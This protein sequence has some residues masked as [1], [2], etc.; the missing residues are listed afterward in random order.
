MSSSKKLSSDGE[1]K[2]S[3]PARWVAVI[4]MPL[5][6]LGGLQLYSTSSQADVVERAMLVHAQERHRDAASTTD[7]Q[8]VQFVQEQ[9]GQDVAEL[10]TIV[11][12]LTESVN[13]LVIELRIR[14]SGVR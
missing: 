4:A 6:G 9:I 7:M 5:F 12:D 2:F 13:E 11:T 10:Q 8:Q 1:V 14:N 3:L